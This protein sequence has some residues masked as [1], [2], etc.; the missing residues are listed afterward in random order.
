MNKT[1][2]SMSSMGCVFQIYDRMQT[3]IPDTGKIVF[4]VIFSLYMIC[5]SCINFLVVYLINKTGQT[6]NQST[7]L[8]KVLS[9]NEGFEAL[10]NNAVYI[11]FLW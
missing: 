5:G 10:F 4:T 8:I 7:F 11:I 1:Q 2:V 3:T 9:L 6:S